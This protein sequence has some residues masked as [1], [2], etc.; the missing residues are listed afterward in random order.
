MNDYENY[1]Q[2]TEEADAVKAMYTSLCYEVK[3]TEYFVK[4]LDVRI[5]ELRTCIVK[6]ELS[7]S[8]KAEVEKR[9]NW[10]LKVKN[11]ISNIS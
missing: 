2:L 4:A 1:L 8:D 6:Y 7:N 10:L 9:I 5:D 3:F 11:A